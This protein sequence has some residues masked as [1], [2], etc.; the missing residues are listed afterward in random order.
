MILWTAEIYV[1][2]QDR[3]VPRGRGTEHGSLLPRR[4]CA[5]VSAMWDPPTP[6]PFALDLS[7]TC[8]L[9]L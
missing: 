1:Q 5:V 3:I 6:L 9:F 7:W 2:L 4:P 8:S